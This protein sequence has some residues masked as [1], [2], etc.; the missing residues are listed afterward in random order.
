MA[1]QNFII[2]MEILTTIK[3]NKIAYL[4]LFIEQNMHALVVELIRFTL[5][6]KNALK[7]KEKYT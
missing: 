1:I 3:I 4:I 7:I 6:L 2:I 5:F